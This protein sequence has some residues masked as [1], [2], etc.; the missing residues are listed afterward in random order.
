M[1][2]R[3]FT[4]KAPLLAAGVLL[5]VT[6]PQVALAQELTLEGLQA[7]TAYVFN[8]L[9]FLVG[10]FLVMFMA[11]GFAMLEA[12]LVRS[13][14]V[15]MQCLKNI[16]LYSIS[17]IMFWVLG[18]SLM[19]SGV[20]G[21]FIGSWL[22]YSWPA[23]GV[24]NEGDYSV[25]SDWFFQMVFCAAT[26]SIVSG[27][28]AERIKLLPFLIFVAVLTGIIYPI[29][30]SWKWGAGWLDGLGF[31]D[32]AGSTIVHSVGGWAALTGAIILGARKG[33]Y[34]PDG[35]VNPMPGSSVPLATLGTF[36]LWLGWFGFNGGSQLAFGDNANA[37]DVSR[38]FI[39]TNF[40]AAGGVVAAIIVM[41]FVYKKIDVTLALNGALAGLVSITAEPLTPGPVMA[42]LIGSVGGVIVVF[43]VPFLDKLKIDDVVGAIPVHLFAGI[44][45][46]IAVVL[47]NGDANLM[48]QIIGILAYGAFA[49]VASGALWLLLKLTIGIRVSAEDEYDGLDKAE[50]G[51]EAYPEFT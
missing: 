7:E 51:V 35:R 33:K 42:I 28:V 32:F 30:G 2:I 6:V 48:T 1:F 38:I 21:G 9:L 11:A 39:N 47:T 36:I 25:G 22:P 26:A 3:K 19:Y 49:V 34:G 45:G 10:G 29:S 46:T 37:S 50:V 27:A 15:S 31:L 40:A 41:A 16:A 18:Y 17:G 20:D 24:A 23:A 14:N 13:K 44:W 12:G 43:A 8:T 4:S 5:S